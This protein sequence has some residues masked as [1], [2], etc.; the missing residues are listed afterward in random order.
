MENSAEEDCLG[1]Q[2]G[3]FGALVGWSIVPAGI[4]GALCW[5]TTQSCSAV[6][7]ASWYMEGNDSVHLKYASGVK[8]GNW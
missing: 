4:K 2:A 3:S 5:L 1:G 8:F 7:T 6:T